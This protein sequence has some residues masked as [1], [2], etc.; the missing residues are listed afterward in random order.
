MATEAPAHHREQPAG[1]IV[2]TLTC[3]T[4]HPRQRKHRGG[5]AL[6]DGLLHGPAPFARIGDHRCDVGKLAIDGEELGIVTDDAHTRAREPARHVG[7]HPARA[8]ESDVHRAGAYH[9]IR[10]DAMSAAVTMSAPP[11]SVRASGSS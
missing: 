1:V 8:D 7:A 10:R 2:A 3:E 11:T 4:R 9:A 5:H 6:L